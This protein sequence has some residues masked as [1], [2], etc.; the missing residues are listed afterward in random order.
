MGLDGCEIFTNSSGS[1]HELRKLNDRI[2]LI[3]RTTHTGGGVYLY[4]NQQGC[5][6]DRLYYDGS[7]LIATNGVL[8][9]QGS[10]FALSDVVQIPKRSLKFL[11][12]Q[13]VITATVDLQE[14][15]SQRGSFNSRSAQAAVVEP[16]QRVVID[17]ALSPVGSGVDANLVPTGRIEP[18][19][20]TPQEEIALGPACWL[21]DYLRRSKA[22]G[23]FLP[24]SGG[25]D[26]CSVATIVFSMCRLVAAKAAED[27]LQVLADSR[28]VVG[29]PEGSTYKPLDPKEFCGCS[30]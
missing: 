26:S 27:D 13:E 24:L 22:S 19:Y 20:H 10:Q 2:S 6:G 7:S 11:T 23:F 16:Y 12:H 4:A 30:L 17:I 1:H 21:W 25:L 15:R 29:E 14:V 8:L 5:D 9:A 28:R 18:R 3:Q